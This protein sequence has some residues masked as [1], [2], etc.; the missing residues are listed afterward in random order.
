MANKCV[1]PKCDAN[2]K[3]LKKN[4]SK[5]RKRKVYSF[6][7]DALLRKKWKNAV[8][9]K[10]WSPTKNSV[11]CEN[12]FLPIDF[13]T[14]RIDNNS[15]RKRKKGKELKRRVL[16]ADTI[17]SQWPNC[18]PVL[19]KLPSKQRSTCRTS[20]SAREDARRVK[21]KLKEDKEREMDKF[22]SLAEL[23]QKLDP[24]MLS[25]EVIVSYTER[26][27]MFLSV[28]Q[29]GKPDIDYCLKVY[30]TLDF[31]MWCKGKIVYK[32]YFPD[33]D[34][35][36]L[37]FVTSCKAIMKIL[38]YLQER[39]IC[40][41][42]VSHAKT[43]K[44][45][46]DEI[47]E[48]LYDDKLCDNRKISFL[49]E[50]LSL[51]FVKP[52]ARRYTPSLLAM[53]F[54]WQSVSPSLYKQI[55]FDGVLTLPSMKRVRKLTS[56]VGTD[57]KLT[58]PATM[59]LKAR[60]SK[61]S[62]AYHQV[63]LLLDEVYCKQMIQYTNGQFYGTAKNE[64]VKT[65]LCVMVKSVR[66]KYRDVVSMTQISNISADKLIN[67][68]QNCISVLSEIGFIAVVTM[69][70]GHKSNES[71]FKKLLE[72]NID[73]FHIDHP[74]FSGQNIFLLFDPVHLFKNFY[75]N[76]MVYDTFSYPNFQLIDGEILRA[77]FAHI[78]QLYDLELGNPVKMAHKLND[79]VLNPS[80]LEKTSVKLADAVFHE[81]TINALTYYG[82]HGYPEFLGTAQFLQII[83][84]WF[85]T[86]N[87]KSAYHGQQTRNPR[88]EC[89]DH[90]NRLQVTDYLIQ[91]HNW[92]SKW[93][94]GAEF[95]GLSKPTFDAAIRTSGAIP[96]LVNY[97]LDNWS[98]EFIL[99]GHIQSDFLEGRFGWYRQLCGANYYNTVLQF[100]QAEK[101]IRIR[102]LVKMGFN[103][104]DIKDIFED[105]E[106]ESHHLE[107]NVMEMLENVENFSFEKLQ[108]EHDEAIVYTVAGYIA[109][110]LIK[111]MSPC[112][113]CSNMLSPGKVPLPL[114]FDATENISS[115]EENIK[116]EFVR[117]ITRGGL[118]KPSDLLYVICT[119][120]HMM[121]TF[122]I[123]DEQKKEILLASC[124]PRKV[125]VET[126]IQKCESNE[127]ANIILENM[128]NQGHSI[129]PFI[130][131]ALTTMFNIFAKNL[132]ADNNS[133]IHQKGKR[134]VNIDNAKSSS[135]AR[136]LKKLISS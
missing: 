43:E 124:N 61:L 121:Y 69:T 132:I 111:N 75:N 126:F 14:E 39:C 79:K 31:E 99:T 90:E 29:N 52:N 100:L 48:R 77:N 55:E 21:E 115:P 86:M 12:H 91:F 38:N 101:T 76:F 33:H 129:R 131:K 57:L 46:L 5:I 68:W 23:D 2:Y 94:E 78:R 102:S 125:F 27:R 113:D 106:T 15:S 112:Q 123:N 64:V 71:F 66:G 108:N 9:R 119:H 13:K 49:T 60:F 36:S 116:E 83:R 59:Y 114:N 53:V 51:V 54:M 26:S 127:F 41:G 7:N 63:P 105:G 45:L 117:N 19:S 65:L 17:P 42:A 3:K 135:S 74:H 56:A 28:S 104:S 25:S 96:K 44:D 24:D 80:S 128:C 73:S 58:E 134:K 11:L 47:V 88:K 89:I 1:A 103:L 133:E 62:P 87:V 4:N 110:N 50:Q 30:D 120:A 37:Q 118:L 18:P 40:N 98:M 95:K 92:L 67:V 32:K 130:V 22:A 10:N 109:R 97:L 72:H 82:T 136:K 20:T 70:D 122:I 84:H 93:H 107:S 35:A 81:S 16:R 8:P 6:P 85:N 34:I